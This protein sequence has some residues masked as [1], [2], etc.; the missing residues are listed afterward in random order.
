M[1]QKQNM[2]RAVRKL[3][4]GQIDPNSRLGI[5]MLEEIAERVFREGLPASKIDTVSTKPFAA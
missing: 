2:R 4:L 5:E 1:A 3:F